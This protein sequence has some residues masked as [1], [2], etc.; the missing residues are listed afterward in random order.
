MAGFL[1]EDAEFRLYT[2]VGGVD[3]GRVDTSEWTLRGTFVPSAGKPVAFSRENFI[4]FDFEDFFIPA[5]TTF[6]IHLVSAINDAGFVLY[7]DLDLGSIVA[8]NSELSVFSGYGTSAA[9][10]PANAGRAFVGAINYSADGAGA[11]P[12]PATWAMLI[13]GFGLIGMAMRG[14][15]TLVA[16]SQ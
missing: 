2:K 16:Q 15:R 7:T 6:G 5:N 3:F 13:T 10:E 14:R 12:E 1:N 11:I 4:E 8:A 9:F